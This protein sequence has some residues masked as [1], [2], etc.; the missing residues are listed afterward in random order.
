[1]DGSLQDR[2]RGA[3]VADRHLDVAAIDDDLRGLGQPALAGEGQQVGTEGQRRDVEPSGEP[4]VGHRR[5]G[6]L[7]VVVLADEV[8]GDRADTLPTVADLAADRAEPT[9]EH[10]VDAGGLLTTLERHAQ[11]R[12]RVAAGADDHLVDRGCGDPTDRPAAD[13]AFGAEVAV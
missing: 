10:R 8:D 11:G 6:P 2:G 3:Q 5:R 9:L 1:V 13:A 12:G 7:D 4:V